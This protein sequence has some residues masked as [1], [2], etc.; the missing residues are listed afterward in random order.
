MTH[1]SKSRDAAT[2]RCRN[3]NYSNSPAIHY[4]SVPSAHPALSLAGG[5][6]CFGKRAKTAHRPSFGVI[7]TANVGA[8]ASRLIITWISAP[9]RVGDERMRPGNP[10]LCDWHFSSAKRAAACVHLWDVNSYF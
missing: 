1:R 6:A 2:L 10:A 7:V 4:F 5:I 8:L 9:L 3:R